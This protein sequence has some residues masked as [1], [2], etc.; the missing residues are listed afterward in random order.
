MEQTRRIDHQPA[1]PA[2]IRTYRLAG[3]VAICGNLLLLA[4]KALVARESGSSAIYSDA[5]NS[6]SDVAHSLLM[7]AGLVLATRPPD[8]RH[9]HGHQ[10]IESLI[11][12]AI[13]MLMVIAGY[14]S[15]RAAITTLRSGAEPITSTWALGVLGF[16][17]VVK[18]AMFWAIS[19]MARSASS[20]VLRANAADNLSDLVSSAMALLGVLLSR[21][22]WAAADPI[23]GIA[24]GVWIVYAVWQVL[25]DSLGQLIGQAAP[26]E[27]SAEIEGAICGVEGVLALERVIVEQ[28]GPLFRADIHIFMEP[29]LTLRAIHRTSHAVRDAVEALPEVDHAF[30]HVEPSWYGTADDQG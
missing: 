16:T 18:G 28:V 6:A 27:L 23:A 10:R 20:P 30:V 22:G 7:M 12:L 17:A 2:Q 4:A 13:G 1:D 21:A 14:E 29:D 9:P 24:V 5:A 15:V 8:A 3:V 25:R 11:S 19:R 26:D